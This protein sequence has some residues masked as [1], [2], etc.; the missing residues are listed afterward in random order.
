MKINA[1]RMILTALLG[2]LATTAQA[3]G[4]LVY[5]SEGSPAGFDT[6]QYSAGTDFDVSA[7]TV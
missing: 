3:A 7:E 1:T 2:G 4:T 6:A 5:C